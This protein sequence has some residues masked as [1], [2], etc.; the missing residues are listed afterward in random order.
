MVHTASDS[1]WFITGLHAVYQVVQ[2]NLYLGFLHG[3]YLAFFTFVTTVWFTLLFATRGSWLFTRFIL[4]HTHCWFFTMVILHWFTHTPCARCTFGSALM[5]TGSWLV[6]ATVTAF[7]ICAGLYLLVT[8]VPHTV[9]LWF[10]TILPPLRCGYGCTR[11]RLAL[12]LPF[13]PYIALYAGLP[14]RHARFAIWF[15]LSHR[16]CPYLPVHIACPYL[17]LHTYALPL[18]TGCYMPLY[19]YYPLLVVYI[20]LVLV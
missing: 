11:T 10:G 1:L 4:P 17:V 2:R 9:P 16:S 15:A 8:V 6:R 14:L 18:L 12:R 3:Y 5:R 20:D 7:A 19:G 13:I